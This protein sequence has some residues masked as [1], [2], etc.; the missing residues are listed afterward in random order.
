MWQGWWLLVCVS[1]SIPL[2]ARVL[3]QENENMHMSWCNKHLTEMNER[4]WLSI[5]DVCR[6]NYQTQYG[7]QCGIWDETADLKRQIYLDRRTPKG[8]KMVQSFL[9]VV[10]LFSPFFSIPVDADTIKKNLNGIDKQLYLSVKNEVQTKREKYRNYWLNTYCSNSHDQWDEEKDFT[11]W[12]LSAVGNMYS[13]VLFSFGFYCLSCSY[14][15]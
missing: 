1:S 2:F 8:Q 6:S 14:Y 13:E 5:A 11:Y 3:Y 10:T 4:Y 12:Q 15:L 9:S 7:S